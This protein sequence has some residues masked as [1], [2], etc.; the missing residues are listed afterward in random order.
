M[1]TV[2]VDRIAPLKVHDAENQQLAKKT[3]RTRMEVFTGRRMAP[4][5]LF[6][7]CVVSLVFR[8]RQEKLNLFSMV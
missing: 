5:V 8:M 6:L 7:L 2:F 1:R 4:G 3:W